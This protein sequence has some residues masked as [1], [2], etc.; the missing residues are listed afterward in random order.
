MGVNKYKAHVWVVPEDD[1][2]RQLANGFLLHPS[3]DGTC[4]DIRQA[5]GGWS[6]V[7]TDFETTHIADLRKYPS[8]HLVLLID[9]DDQ[10]ED[11]TR[12]FRDRF[13]RDVA[14]RVY[15][16]G[17]RSEPE[18]LRKTIGQPFE[19]IGEALAE[20]CA[21]GF[22]GPWAHE[23]LK[24]NEAELVRLIADVKPFLFV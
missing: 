12:L 22:P 9:F 15:V 16:I 19:K 6:K 14:S 11:R 1:A 7:L 4:I 13:P 21:E 24:H 18:P 17:S 20:S 10:V 23:L 8:R 2:T 3:V 5:P